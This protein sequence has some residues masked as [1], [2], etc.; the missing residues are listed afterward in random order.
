[1]ISFPAFRLPVTCVAIMAVAHSG[2]AGLTLRV[3]VAA[4]SAGS[5]RLLTASISPRRM[6][7]SFFRDFFGAACSVDGIFSTTC[8]RR[9]LE[10]G[11]VAWGA[12]ERIA[13]MSGS[14]SLY[15]CMASYSIASSSLLTPSASPGSSMSRCDRP[16]A[17]ALAE[18]ELVLGTWRLSF[19]GRTLGGPLC[20]KSSR[21]R[22]RD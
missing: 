9:D 3:S 2:N 13:A 22:R 11:V 1:M 14:L 4:A 8:G 7:V 17:S 21:C 15:D 5:S 19:G 6:L 12:S 20:S 16:R 10:A 18:A